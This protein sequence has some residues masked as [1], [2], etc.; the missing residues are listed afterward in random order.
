MNAFPSE[1]ADRV[2]HLGMELRDYF[3]AKAMQSLILTT[4]EH[5]ENEL[6]DP[7]VDAPNIA[8]WAYLYADQMIRASKD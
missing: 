1:D 6:N 3:A 2:F 4:K 8:D 5:Y 7:Y